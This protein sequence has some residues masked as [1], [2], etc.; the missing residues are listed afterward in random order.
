MRAFYA[1]HRATLISKRI[2]TIELSGSGLAR[3]TAVY[4]SEST[5]HVHWGV[6]I[7]S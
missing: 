6:R 5:R 2:I 7:V 1:A 4:K 3:S